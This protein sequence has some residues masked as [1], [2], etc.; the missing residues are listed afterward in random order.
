MRHGVSTTAQLSQ[1]KPFLTQ[2]PC[3]YSSHVYQKQ[4]PNIRQ[5]LIVQAQLALLTQQT[6]QLKI[7]KTPINEGVWPTN[8]LN[9]IC[10]RAV[11]VAVRTK[12]DKNFFRV[13]HVQRCGQLVMGWNVQ[14]NTGFKNAGKWVNGTDSLCSR[15]RGGFKLVHL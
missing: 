12:A 13:G 7:T 3:M 1:L 8:K 6:S 4:C 5:S 9:K 14:F 10:A 15:G 11:H 2:A